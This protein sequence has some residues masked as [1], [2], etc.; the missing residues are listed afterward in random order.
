MIRLLI[1]LLIAALAL[2]TL[3]LA[4]S[5]GDPALGFVGAGSDF[6]ALHR[7]GAVSVKV[8]ADWSALEPAKG[9]FA[10]KPLDETIAAATAAGLRVVVVLTYTPKWASL[11][12]GADLN[13]PQIYSRQP[14]K[15]IADWEAF[16][17]AIVGR[18]KGKV[19]DWQVWT[20]L[21]LPLFRGTTSDYLGLLRAARTK[22][23]AADPASRIV[24][25][26]PLG[27]D[28]ASVRHALDR[29]GGSFDAVSL[30]P[31]GISPETL[32]RYLAVLRERVLG[33]SPKQVWMDW[34]PRSAGESSTWASQ[35]TKV[36]AVS[37]AFGVD[38]LFWASPPNPETQA[39]RR[40]FEERVGTRPFVGYIDRP[41][42]VVLAFG[43]GP[44]S[45]VAWRTGA[46]AEVDVE[47][48]ASIFAF[49]GESRPQTAAA[50][51]LTVMLS[52]EPLLITDAGAA[53]AAAAK[54]TLQNRGLPL[55]P[56]AQS[57]S[58]AAEVSAR[59][60]RANVEK[61]LYNMRFRDRRNGAVEVVDVDGGEAVRTNASKDIVFVYFDVD[62][63]F[64][65]FVDNRAAVEIAVEV[66]GAGA[67]QQ[68]GFNLLYDSTSGYRFTPWQWVEAG[69]GWVTYTFRITD[70]NFANT[71]GWDFAINAG[72]NRREDLT[73]RTVTV[74]KVPKS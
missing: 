52:T 7:S 28:L 35:M 5:G 53:V 29:A 66:R 15:R 11:A 48:A 62:D 23:K 16:V 63:T 38:Q 47:P 67:A 50:D 10:W 27:I 45:L 58:D 30:H 18:Y 40:T 20:S 14:A 33:A 54:S 56:A 68:L 1:C 73:I 26:T 49:T 25:S 39:A 13:N 74:R 4:Q 6:A 9:Q 3:V 42:A 69:H 24:L 19:R 43:E 55:P 70:A 34:D 12:T 59:L 44:T 22:S 64:L 46:E 57:F 37:R 31:Q 65:F 51:K 2:P 8:I 21:S 72:G 61:G 32:M 17:T 60:G 36:L 41:G 71:W